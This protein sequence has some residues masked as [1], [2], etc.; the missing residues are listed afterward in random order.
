MESIENE[1]AAM[2]RRH[3]RAAAATDDALHHIALAL[4]AHRS[5]ASADDM[6]VDVSPDPD[7]DPQPGAQPDA[8][9]PLDQLRHLHKLAKGLQ[10]ALVLDH[11]SVGATINKLGRAIDA[12]TFPHLGGLCAPN[13]RLNTAKINDAIASHLFRTGLFDI[14]HSFLREAHLQLHDDHIRPFRRLHDI[15]TAFRHQDLR[16]AI[17]WREENEDALRGSDEHLLFRLHRLAYLQILGTGDRD[18]AL[19]YA[20]AH[21]AH[22]P[23]HIT[24]VQRLMTCLLYVHKLAESPYRD[25]VS[26]AHRDSIERALS[27]EYCRAQGMKHDPSLVTVVRCGTKAIPTLIKASRVAPTLSDLGMDDALP[28]EIDVGRECQFHSI[29]TCPVS[30]EEASEGNNMPMMLPCGHVLSN[31]SILRLPRG[32]HR[33]KCPYCPM[34]QVGSECREVH[35]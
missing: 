32:S 30:K 33:F 27:R 28:V 22:F 25:L 17:A 5:P 2:R 19:A 9:S 1:Y 7:P 23:D 26:P 15:L 3:H 4:E 21:F 24:S 11:K 10:A 35:F 12:A 8:D 16:P 6:Q 29:F 14:G 31:Q 18:A 20:R 13:V 34:E